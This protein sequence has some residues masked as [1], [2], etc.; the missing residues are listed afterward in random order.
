MNV[1]SRSQSKGLT[2]KPR[3]EVGAAVI[4]NQGNI[5]ISQRDD[6][7]HLSGLWEFPGGK[8]E[9]NESFE[10]C[11]R[12][13]IQEELNVEVAVENL[14][15]AVEYEYAEKIVLLKFYRCQYVG[16]EPKALG[17]RQFQWVSPSNLP[18]YTF[19]PANET[20]IQKLI[21]ME[22]SKPA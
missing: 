6:S 1:E 20:V 16:G 17:C 14:F 8:R 11:V 4:F 18:S 19:P 15:E 7:S 13:E 22:S 10:E 2:T 9:D 21:Q 12:R 3:I 5:L